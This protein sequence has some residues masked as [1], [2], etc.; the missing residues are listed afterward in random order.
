MT[1]GSNL[2]PAE[3]AAVVV[4]EEG[5]SYCWPRPEQ[6]PRPKYLPHASP[7]TWTGMGGQ[8]RCGG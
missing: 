4:V 6:R 1:K 5:A 3:A 7:G 8:I 2:G